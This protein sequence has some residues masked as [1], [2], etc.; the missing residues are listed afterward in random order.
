[1]QQ[2]AFM[3]THLDKRV[4]RRAEK[5]MGSYSFIEA[6]IQSQ[7]LDL[8]EQSMTVNYNASE[9]QRGNQFHSETE[10]IALLRVKLS[11]H[12]KTK[13]KLDRIYKSLK[14]IQR[15]IWDLRYI[16]GKQDIDV[17]NELFIPDRSYYRLKREMIAIVAEAFC[18]D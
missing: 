13:E 4:R 18:L 10:R 7:K 8:P 15:R 3:D 2:L 6:I 9:S 14:P 16:D 1:M 11:E 5:L 17:Y 12:I